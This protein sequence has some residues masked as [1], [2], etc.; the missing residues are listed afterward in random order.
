MKSI[1]PLRQ[2]SRRPFFVPILLVQFRTPMSS[3]QLCRCLRT[4]VLVQLRRLRLL[5]A[6]RSSMVL[7]GWP[8][9]SSLTSP[10]AQEEPRSSTNQ[11]KADDTT[12]HA[13]CDGTY[14]RGG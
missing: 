9:S 14:R 4:A 7:G 3:L 11:S 6:S 13:S 5:F 10:F 8:L 1:G 12:D 2:F